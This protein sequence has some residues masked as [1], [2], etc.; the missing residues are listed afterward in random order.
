LGLKATCQLLFLSGSADAS[1][2]TRQTATI[3][4]TELDIAKY[5]RS[6][7][8]DLNGAQVTKPNNNNKQHFTPR[9]NKQQRVIRDSTP[10][11]D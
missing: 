7:C 2:S 8:A 9:E 5:Y 10:W 6:F 4:P 3:Y 1:V 11:S